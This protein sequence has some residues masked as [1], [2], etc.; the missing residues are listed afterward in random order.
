MVRY[1][2]EDALTDKEFVLLLEGARELQEPFDMQ[3][4]FIIMA[5]GRLG[6]RGGEIAHISEDWIDSASNIVKI[7]EHDK[8]EKGQS[9][10]EMCG[11]C[12]N[13]VR[14]YLETNNTTIE[15]EIKSLDREYGDSI[16]REAKEVMAKQKVENKNKSVE[17]IY[18]KWWQPKTAASERSI[19]YDFDTR[20][21][22]CVERFF[23]KY[24]SFPISKAS[25]NRRVTAA[26]DSSQLNKRIYPHSLRATAATT[27]ASRDVSPYALMSVMG[28]RDMDTARTYVAASDESAARDIIQSHN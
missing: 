18:H 10:G 11:Y 13:R 27:H 1:S 8:C 24:N 7:P 3:A 2:R 15:E 6:M 28:W 23:E 4:R 17:D 21:H 22:L 20:L 9:E 26:A 5:A 25:L 12:R 14:D 16:E 19:P